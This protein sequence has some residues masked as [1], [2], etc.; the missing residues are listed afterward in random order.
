M[1]F[2]ASIDWRSRTRAA[3]I[4]LALSA[5]VA[6]GAAALVFGLWYPWP[7]NIVSGGGELFTLLISVDVV[8]G[9]MIT[10]AIFDRRKGWPHLRRDL[11]IVAALQLA[12]LG[13]GLHTVFVARPVA[14]ALEGA[15]RFR[16]VSAVDVRDDD[17]AKAPPEFRT[18][19]LTGPR[20]VRTV[21]PTDPAEKMEALDLAFAG[22]DLG[23]RPQFWREWDDTAR[24]EVLTRAKP[25]AELERRYPAR[26]A[27]LT[28]AVERSGRAAEALRYLPLISFTGQWVV[29]VD[30]ERG[31]IVGFAPFDGFF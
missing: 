4:H 13:Y 12:A 23:M 25:F 14:V 1:K 19:S 24:R 16:V 30:A 10:W 18:L 6:A 22:R 15:K 29:L 5:A 2:I 26:R 28:A 11:A 21:E 7:H 3:L 9:P 20:L 31:E 8:L 27:E 17:L